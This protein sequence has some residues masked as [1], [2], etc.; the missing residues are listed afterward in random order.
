MTSVSNH[1]QLGWK[2][3]SI[4]FTS[5]QEKTTHFLRRGINVYGMCVT[6]QI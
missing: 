4:F 2:Y 1:G 3:C 6:D 5:V